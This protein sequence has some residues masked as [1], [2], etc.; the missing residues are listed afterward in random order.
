MVRKLAQESESIRR[1][2][3]ELRDIMRRGFHELARNEAEKSGPDGTD[4]E[5]P[6]NQRTID[7]IP[8]VE[9]LKGTT[10]GAGLG[11]WRRSRRDSEC[12]ATARF[13]RREGTNM[14]PRAR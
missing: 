7:Q 10:G 5:K 12:A 6:G 1:E 14:T 9:K 11:K 2:M 4:R 3:Q 13:E 8:P